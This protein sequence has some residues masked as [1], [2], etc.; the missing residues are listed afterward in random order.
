MCGIRDV[1]PIDCGPAGDITRRDVI[2]AASEAARNTEEGILRTTICFINTTADRTGSG[3]VARV[4]EYQRHTGQSGFVFDKGTQLIERPRMQLASLRLTNPYPVTDTAEVFQSDPAF[5]VFSLIHKLL[6]DLVVHIGCKAPFLAGEVLEATARGL[7]TF[8]LQPCAYPVVATAQAAHVVAGV[9]R[10]V[11]VNGDIGNA[12]IDAEIAVNV[13]RFRL[14][15]VACG[16]QVKLAAHIAEVG[17]AASG[18]DQFHIAR[19]GHE[20]DSDASPK[21]P[22]RNGLLFET[23]GKNTVIVRDGRVLGKSALAFLTGLIGIG[24]TRNGTDGHLSRQAELF[25]NIVIGQLVKR[26][27]L[28][29]FGFPRLSRYVVTRGIGAFHR[30]EQGLML[31]IGGKQLN[32]RYKFHNVNISTDGLPMQ[33]RT[34]FAVRIPLPLKRG[35]ILRRFL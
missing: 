23:V 14:V 4:N 20:R 32:S 3:S 27:L 16:Q 10:A 12:K 34:A 28:E 5:G 35:S 24:H 17:L 7:R 21:R 30:I 33:E 25:P 26:E 22:E 1:R 11:T 18:L 2:G 15:N 13:N 8:R 29:G 31:F 9:E 19:P 6:A